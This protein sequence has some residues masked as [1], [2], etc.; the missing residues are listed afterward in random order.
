MRVGSLLF[1]VGVLFMLLFY[2]AKSNTEKKTFIPQS[3]GFTIDASLPSIATKGLS[4]IGKLRYNLTLTRPAD[5]DDDSWTEV[6]FKLDGL[7]PRTRYEARVCWPATNPTEFVLAIF[8]TEQYRMMFAPLITSMKAKDGDKAQMLLRLCA[9]PDIVSH[10][11]RLMQSKPE[12]TFDIII[13]PLVFDVLPRSLVGT[14]I[15]ILFTLLLAWKLVIPAAM[16]VVDE[17]IGEKR[18]TVAIQ[19]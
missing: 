2:S 10:I 9:R 15:L 16:S 18:K 13:D 3:S 6:W 19:T 14:V 8:N 7:A 11:P 17:A 1:N 12:V 5:R 4:G